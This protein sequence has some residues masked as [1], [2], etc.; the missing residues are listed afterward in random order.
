LKLTYL[1][2]THDLSVVRQFAD[3]IG[4]AYS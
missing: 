3:R 1:F 4:F 2:I